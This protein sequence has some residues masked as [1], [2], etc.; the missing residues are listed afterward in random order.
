MVRLKTWYE[1]FQKSYIA[2]EDEL[3]RRKK[4][5]AEL[6]R[7]VEAFRKY[8]QH[9][10]QKEQAQR[11]DFNEKHHRYLPPNLKLLLE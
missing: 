9:E 2:M 3:V 1:Y 6:E 5:E 4:Q 8:L 7:K 10:M 11:V